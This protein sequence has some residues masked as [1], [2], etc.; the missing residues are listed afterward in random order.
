ML[1]ARAKIDGVPIEPGTRVFALM[2]AA[3]LTEALF[4][5]PKNFDVT[6]NVAPGPLC[7]E[8]DDKLLGNVGPAALLGLPVRRGGS[9][10][11]S[12]TYW[13]SFSELMIVWI[14]PRMSGIPTHAQASAS[15]QAAVPV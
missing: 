1:G 7:S 14:T 3:H 9:V 15:C 10:V 8:R 11:V 2:W 12:L 13:K 5:N 6:R 4:P